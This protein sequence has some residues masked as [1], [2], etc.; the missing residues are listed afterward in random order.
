HTLCCGAHVKVAAWV[1]AIINI[2]S[3]VAIFRMFLTAAA[4]QVVFVLVV[5]AIIAAVFADAVGNE[6]SCSIII[7]IILM[8][9]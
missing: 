6:R 9:I 5:V 7:A 4:K 8:V 3:T 1:I 2:I